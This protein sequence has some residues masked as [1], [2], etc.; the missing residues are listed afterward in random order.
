MTMLFHVMVFDSVRAHIDHVHYKAD[1][2][3]EGQAPAY[4]DRN[5]DN[6][7]LVLTFVNLVYKWLCVDLRLRI[8]AI[9][10]DLHVLGLIQVV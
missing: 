3:E 9:V 4:P 5:I 6:V 8:Y 2:F 1:G 7:H 10:D